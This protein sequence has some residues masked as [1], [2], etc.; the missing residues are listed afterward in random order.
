M[1]GRRPRP[2]ERPCRPCPEGGPGKDG[3]HRPSRTRPQMR[4]SARA[5][6][7]GGVYPPN[8]FGSSAREAPTGGLAG[9]L[10]EA[11]EVALE[12]PRRPA[13]GS[14]RAS[15]SPALRRTSSPRRVSA[16]DHTR[17]TSRRDPSCASRA[18]SRRETRQRGRIPAARRRRWAFSSNGGAG[19]TRGWRGSGR[20]GAR[21]SLVGRFG[22]VVSMRE[23]GR[24]AARRPFSAASVEPIGRRRDPRK[25]RSCEGA[26]RTPACRFHSGRARKRALSRVASG[27]AS[28]RIF[29]RR[30]LILRLQ[31]FLHRDVIVPPALEPVELA[32]GCASLCGCRRRPAKASQPAA[33]SSRVDGA[34]PG[35]A[36]ASS[37]HRTR[38]PSRGARA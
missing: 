37:P 7:W 28:P 14:S 3:R 18:T 36:G 5:E 19:S 35:R 1:S 13:T 33:L 11:L 29:L 26:P 2:R 6:A 27:D 20:G 8:G 38:R 32:T 34:V 10:A 25:R 12:G 15:P 30:L 16:C 9:A 23:I 4:G 31:I 21:S 17:P 24:R 22:L